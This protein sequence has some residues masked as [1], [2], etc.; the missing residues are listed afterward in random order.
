L[1][2]KEKVQLAIHDALHQ[3]GPQT[4]NK[5]YSLVIG[6]EK[7]SNK[8]FAR[9]LSILVE[10]GKVKKR[11]DGQ[12]R[13]YSLP[14]IDKNE[15]D[16]NLS[17]F[18]GFLLN[19]IKKH[20]PLVKE[21]LKKKQK[22]RKYKDLSSHDQLAIYY[23]LSDSV[24]L[25][26]N[27]SK[28]THLMIVAGF[29]TTENRQKAKELQK[30][31][32]QILRDYFAIARKIHF[33]IGQELFIDVLDDIK[34]TLGLSLAHGKRDDSMLFTLKEQIDFHSNKKSKKNR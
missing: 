25:T 13:E 14:K 24:I 11:E 19:D 31:Y 18:L 30:L 26:L 1:N 20:H 12:K 15:L 29:S 6:I 22:S 4:F 17:K 3:N 8:T 2:S 5:L 23:T 28:M 7:C 27:W 16:A 34:P 32:N 10:I 21:R 9:H 33:P